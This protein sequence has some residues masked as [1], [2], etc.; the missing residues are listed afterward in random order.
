MGNVFKT[1]TV[2]VETAILMLALVCMPI[3]VAYA[4]RKASALG[5]VLAISFG[6]VLCAV[7]AFYY[8]VVS[9]G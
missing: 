3:A 1:E 2:T 4:G 7:G 9:G 8:L 5:G 6:V